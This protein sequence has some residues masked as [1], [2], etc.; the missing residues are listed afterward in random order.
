MD[1]KSYYIIFHDQL[2]I[3]LLSTALF[4]PIRQLVWILHVRK[5][6]KIDKLVSEEE[7]K[8]LKKRASFTSFFLSIVFSY[9][10]VSQV[11]N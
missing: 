2:W 8:N 1:F 7:K 9:I 4:F 10:Y 11:F 6:Q 3:I 5:K